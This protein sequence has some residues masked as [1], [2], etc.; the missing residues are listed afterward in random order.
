MRAHSAGATAL[1]AAAARLDSEYGGPHGRRAC[2]SLLFSRSRR[3]VISAGEP[4]DLK[5]AAPRSSALQSHSLDVTY[6]LVDAGPTLDNAPVFQSQVL[7]WIGVQREAG[8]SVGL[9]ATVDEPGRFGAV[10]EPRLREMGVPWAGVPSGRLAP[11]VMRAARAFRRFNRE[12][13]SRNAYV[14]GVWGSVAHAIAHPRRGPRLIYDLRGDVLQEAAYR[15]AGRLR[16]LALRRLLTFAIRRADALTC[17]STAA[18]ELLQRDHHRQVTAVIPSCVD[19]ARLAATSEERA[20]TRAELGYSDSD[21]VL[22]YA[23]G[24]ARYQLIPEM[25]RLWASLGQDTG[26]QFLLLTNDAP[27]PGPVREGEHDPVPPGL[28]RMSVPR[29]DVP[30]YLSAADVGFLLREPHPLNR[31]ASP[32]KFGE[33]LAAGLAV[34][35]SPGIGDTSA[36]VTERGLGELVEVGAHDRTLARCRALIASLRQDREGFRERART[37]AA[38]VLDWKCYLPVWKQLLG[39]TG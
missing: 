31:V 37:A 22:V 23:G 13:P 4:P 26:V 29:S 36:M 8:V 32:V 3:V 35:T 34:V 38:E 7:D 5:N 21:V 28:R 30:R 24:L 14:R 39:L 20:A 27:A 33:Y 6:L 25:L 1:R 2:G 9:V 19:V 15:G 17:V 11:T 10:V 16:Q 18:A 12:F